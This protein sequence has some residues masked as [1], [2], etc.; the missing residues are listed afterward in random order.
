MPPSRSAGSSPTPTAQRLIAPVRHYLVSTRS[1]ERPPAWR[2]VTTPAASVSET[3]PSSAVAPA[4]MPPPGQA[5]T[6]LLT[7]RPAMGIASADAAPH[8]TNADVLNPGDRAGP[9]DLVIDAESAAA[10]GAATLDPN[11]RYFDG[12]A[13]PPT[14][15]A[16]QAYRAQFA[17]MFQL[18]PESVFAEARGGVHGQHELLLHRPIVPDETLQ[19]VIETHSVRPS[20]ENLRITLLHKTYDAEEHLVAEQ[21]WTTVMLGTTAEPIGPALP[22]H[23]VSGFRRSASHCRGDRPNRSG[24]GAPLQRRSPATSASITSTWKRPAEV[25]TRA[26]FSM[27]FAPWPCVREPWS[28]RYATE[29]PLASRGSPFVSP[30]LPSSTGTS[31]FG[32]TPSAEIATRWR[33]CA[34]RILSSAMAW[35]SCEPQLPCERAEPTTRYRIPIVSIDGIAADVCITLDRVM[36]RQASDVQDDASP[37]RCEAGVGGCA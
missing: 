26:R 27:A 23:A 12:T 2:P 3:D 1:G 30:L 22:D 25:G 34:V 29:I 21:W 19:T 9:Y 24:H 15:I 4:V 6:I 11:P 16:T 14:A 28:E 13:L 31:R 8:L 32:S 17:A 36:G 5:R 7:S 37:H 33:Q 10:F 35:P 18:V 20:G